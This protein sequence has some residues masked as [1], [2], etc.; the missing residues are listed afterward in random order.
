MDL[1]IFGYWGGA[2]AYWFELFWLLI[3]G[4]WDTKPSFWLI[5][6]WSFLLIELG[7]FGNVCF[8]FDIELGLFD[9][10]GSGFF[11]CK[12]LELGLLD[13][14]LGFL[15]DMSLILLLL[16]WGSRILIWGFWDIEQGIFEYWTGSIWYG[17]WTG[18]FW[19]KWILNFLVIEVIELGPL[20]IDLGFC[21]ILIWSFFHLELELFASYGSGFFVTE[22]GL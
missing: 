21:W 10:Y 2:F 11:D 18:A 9:W 20:D 12:A 4:F 7:L 1:D 5:W 19:L 16:S 13:I 8:V 22:L 17:Y 6:I 15:I 14:E 3:W